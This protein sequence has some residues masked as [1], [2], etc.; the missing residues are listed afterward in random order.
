ML[1]SKPVVKRSAIPTPPRRWRSI[2]VHPMAYLLLVLMVFFGVIITA[3]SMGWWSTSGRTS[4]D[5]TPIQATGK[6]PAEIK[7]WMTVGEVLNAYNVPKEELYIRFGIPA[8]VP[9]T[10]QLKSLEDIAPN[11]SVID[12]RAWLTERTP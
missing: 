2:D 1:H 10:T 9:E 12:L 11:F 8:D 7:G 6:D 4:A 3:Q 5:G